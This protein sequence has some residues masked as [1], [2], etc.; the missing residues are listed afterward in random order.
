SLTGQS[1]GNGIGKGEE[2]NKPQA[3]VT[4]LSQAEEAMSP[5]EILA[6]MVAR[7]WLPGEAKYKKRFYATLSRMNSE[8]RVRRLP[9]GSYVL[10]ANSQEALAGR[11]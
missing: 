5:G 3:I 7:K 2:P 11:F 6:E 1:I 8:E 9:N 4:I 10:P